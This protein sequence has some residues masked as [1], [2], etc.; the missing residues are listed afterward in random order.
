LFTALER[1]V[2]SAEPLAELELVAPVPPE[3]LELLDEHAASSI[4]VQAAA[5]PNA[6]RDAR[7]LPLPIVKPL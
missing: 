6:T 5:T 7:G 4:A 3:L 1:A 2:M